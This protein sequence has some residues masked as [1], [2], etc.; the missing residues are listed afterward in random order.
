[1][2]STDD[3]P[4][5]IGNGVGSG[6]SSLINN[7]NSLVS[8]VG[9]STFGR[10]TNI[11]VSTATTTKVQKGSASSSS[12][13]SKIQGITRKVAGRSI[14]N[15]GNNNSSSSNNRSDNTKDDVQSIIDE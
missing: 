6:G 10:I 12:S 4:A 3:I 2:S 15:L 8:K 14:E 1:M 11:S 13:S 9:K 5:A 7:N